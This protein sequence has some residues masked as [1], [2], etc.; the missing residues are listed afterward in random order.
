MKINSNI[1]DFQRVSIQLHHMIFSYEQAHEKL[2]GASSKA[3]LQELIKGL[4]NTFEMGDIC[5][6]SRSRSLQDNVQSFIDNLNMSEY[7]DDVK[8]EYLNG[9]YVFE[10][11]E[12]KFAKKGSHIF[13]K[14]K[15]TCPF[16]ILAAAIIYYSTNENLRIHETE[17]DVHSSRTVIE[18]MNGA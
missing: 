15:H 5:Y 14:H 3:I 9:T 12:C 11:K 18:K 10:I 7:F 4:A 17:F 16:A 6:I 2:V 8:V 13:L 1:D